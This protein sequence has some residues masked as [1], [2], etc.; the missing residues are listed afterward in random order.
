M[1]EDFFSK[2]RNYNN[3]LEKILEKKD[4][5]KDSKNLLLSMFYKL[6]N[7]YDDYEIVKRKVKSKQEYLE[8]I[9]VNIKQCNKIELIKPNTKKFEDFREKR[10]TCNIDLKLKKIEVIDNELFL[11]SAIFELNDFSI[12]LGE[13]YNLIRNSFPYLLN[14]AYDMN[15]TEVLRDFN[16]F[17]WNTN[18]KELKDININLAYEILRLT[19]SMD[20]IQKLENS[21]DAIDIIEIIN[22]S[23]TSLYGE[24][25]SEK[26]LNL[27]FKISIAI[28]TRNS[29]NERKRLL[30]EKE[31]IKQELMKI[32]DKKS[33]INNVIKLK[34]ELTKKVKELDLILNDRELLLQEFEKR[35]KNLSKYYKILNLSHLSEKIQKEKDK[36]LKKIEECNKNV[37]PKNYIKNREKLNR[38]LN[39][40]ESISIDNNSADKLYEYIDQ[41]LVLFFKEI[42]YKK[43]ELANT[44]EDLLNLVYQIRYYL[45]LP[46]EHEKVINE[47]DKFKELKINIIT[48]IIKKMYKYKLIRTMSTNGEQDIKIVS[49]LFSLRMIS[50]EE[51]YLELHKMKDGNYKLNI[52]DEKDT[53]EQ[54]IQ[55]TLNFNKKDRIKLKKKI[56][57]F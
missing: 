2:F 50:L 17:S 54:S 45:F 49:T 19:L 43:I 33:Y 23:L 5:S 16:A 32:N 35:N 18:S 36:L 29:T 4:F 40:L 14:T 15:N 24:R 31:I 46:Y 27:L 57:L 30:E 39:L 11:L 6:E 55:L 20:I 10:I 26:I 22:K 44:K 56:K 28:Y 34:L 25:L 9:L 42:L 13:E 47:I 3:E 12:Y 53:L 7:S 41:L 8:N 51:V 21:N 52:Y 38:D 37:E 48:L 1:R